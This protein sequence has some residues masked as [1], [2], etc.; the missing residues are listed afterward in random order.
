MAEHVTGQYRFPILVA[1]SWMEDPQLPTGLSMSDDLPYQ[2]LIIK[3]LVRYGSVGW[4]FK[5]LLSLHLTLCC[6]GT[7]VAQAN[8]LFSFYQAVIG[9]T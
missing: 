9:V 8:V 4:V 3:D 7:C 5:I 1:P 2:C 6:L